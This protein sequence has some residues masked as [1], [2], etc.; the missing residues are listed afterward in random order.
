MSVLRLA[1][2]TLQRVASYLHPLTYRPVFDD[3]LVEKKAALWEFDGK[4]WPSQDDELTLRDVRNFANTCRDIR[5]AVSPLLGMTIR[6]TSEEHLNMSTGSLRHLHLI[7]T[8]FYLSAEGQTR[9]LAS[10]TPG[11]MLSLSLSVFPYVLFGNLAGGFGHSDPYEDLFAAVDRLQVPHLRIVT[12]LVGL[13]PSV[14]KVKSC[15]TLEIDDQG[16]WDGGDSTPYSNLTPRQHLTLRQLILQTKPETLIYRRRKI[17]HRQTDF[18]FFNFS[19]VLLQAVKGLGNLRTLC[20]RNL[21]MTE[22]QLIELFKSCAKLSTFEYHIP[23]VHQQLPA[24]PRQ[25]RVLRTNCHLSSAEDSIPPH[26]EELCVT[27]DGPLIP[28]PPDLYVP[29]LPPLQRLH[30]HV[31]P[32]VTIAMLKQLL[33]KMIDLRDLELFVLP[34]P[35]S[36]GCGC[37]EMSEDEGKTLSY[38]DAMSKH[39]PPD[40]EQLGW[41]EEITME[42]LVQILRPLSVVSLTINHDHHLQSHPFPDMHHLGPTRA[43]EQA[44][45]WWRANKEFYRQE[46]QKLFDGV[47]GL[48]NIQWRVCLHDNEAWMRWVRGSPGKLLSP[49]PL[50]SQTRPGESPQRREPSK[51]NRRQG[52]GV[53]EARVSKRTGQQAMTLPPQS[54]LLHKARPSPAVAYADRSVQTDFPRTVVD[55]SFT[56]PSAD[57]LA[58]LREQLR[59]QRISR[60][61]AELKHVQ[62][63][64]IVVQEENRRLRWEVATLEKQ[65]LVERG[66]LGQDWSE[67]QEDLLIFM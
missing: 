22:E 32:G 34:L 43:R 42:A 29:H 13:L 24:L 56:D 5:K 54:L 35:W 36:H 26:L 31:S 1:P 57:H 60:L 45:V 53:D 4:K 64:K 59:G 2:E 40:P 63:E 23:E 30:A 25:L 66:R 38:T 52:V 61:S 9:L 15:T 46:T 55:P 51:T 62:K 49:Q 19:N 20:L 6:A 47:E 10:I 37:L 50:I 33:T 65:L 27:H 8:T 44:G 14:R 11:Q 48:L 3:A 12:N 7:P 58:D 41:R 18:A 67:E 39:P 16:F 17:P 28:S 21:Q